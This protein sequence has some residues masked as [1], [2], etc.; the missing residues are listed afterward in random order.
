MSYWQTRLI[1]GCHL[2]DNQVPIFQW[3]PYLAFSW[4]RVRR[5]RGWGIQRCSVVSKSANG[6][7]FRLECIVEPWVSFYV[8]I[9]HVSAFDTTIKQNPKIDRNILPYTF[10]T[11]MAYAA[12]WSIQ[13]YIHYRQKIWNI[14][15][16]SEFLHFCGGC[17]VFLYFK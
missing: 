4:L 1:R 3:I 6:S 2:D 8:P 11:Y 17:R 7:A 15:Y 16:F 13:I 5:G 10:I 12:S 14:F 9:T